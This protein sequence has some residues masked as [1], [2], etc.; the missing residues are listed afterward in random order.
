[1]IEKTQKQEKRPNERLVLIIIG[2]F[3]CWD[4]LWKAIKL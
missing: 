4:L 1:M 3:N 2:D